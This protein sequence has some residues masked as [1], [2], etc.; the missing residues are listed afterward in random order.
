MSIQ[1][2]QSWLKTGLYREGQGRGAKAGETVWNLMGRGL[3]G[4]TEAGRNGTPLTI[5]ENRGELK[6]AQPWT[7]LN[8]NSTGGQETSVE[9]VATHRASQMPSP[10]WGTAG[11]GGLD[12]H[13]KSTSLFLRS[14][15]LSDPSQA[16]AQVPSAPLYG[17][18]SELTPQQLFGEVKEETDFNIRGPDS[19]FLSDPGQQES[20]SLLPVTSS[21]HTLPHRNVDT[22]RESQ[23]QNP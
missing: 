22:K 23:K 7:G 13:G 10:G 2:L 9:S 5:C 12:S 3:E 1:A 19:L 11:S 4:Q 21:V 17:S 14:P 8:G 20:L 15:Q 6:E 18:T 16:A